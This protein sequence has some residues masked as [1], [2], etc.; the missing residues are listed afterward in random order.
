MKD[1]QDKR[2]SDKRVSFNHFSCLL[3]HPNTRLQ[4]VRMNLLK[5]ITPDHITQIIITY[6]QSHFQFN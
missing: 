4:N 2:S 3:N 5:K 6:T 1:N